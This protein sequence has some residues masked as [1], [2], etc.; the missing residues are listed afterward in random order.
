LLHRNISLTH[1]PF[2]LAALGAALCWTV[3]GIISTPAARHLGAIAFTRI[4]M[5]IVFVLMLFWVLP[6]AG[7]ATIPGDQ[8]PMIIA[9]GL[10]GIYLGDTALFTVMAR[11]GPRRTGVL[12]ATNAPMTVLISWFWFGDTLTGME[13]AG[14][15]AV[16]CG[17][18][19]AILYG[20]AQTGAHQLEKVQGLLLVGIGLG[21]F[22][23]FCQ[24]V[25]A[26][27]TKPALSN[28]ADPVAIT[29]VRV[30]V[31]VLALYITLLFPLKA[32]KARNPLNGAVLLRTV[33][34]G[35]IGLALAMSLL[36]YAYAGGNA[37]IAATLSSTAPVLMLPLLWLVTRQMPGAIAWTGAMV[38]VGGSALILL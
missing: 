17:V 24:A 8:W 21:L 1:I 12:F 20:R 38:C 31:S 36:M 14:C 3:T 5:S 7:F 15:L 13:M 28:G 33:A 37:G 34:T 29:A 22:A 11:L 2:E 23:A 35:I 10:I 6:T 4:R 9:S 26:L 18:A 32:Q 30:G 19:L 27:M 16:V 25:G